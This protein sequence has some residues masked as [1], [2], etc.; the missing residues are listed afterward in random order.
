MDF[1]SLDFEFVIVAALEFILTKSIK[2]FDLGNQID[3][4][5]DFLEG[6]RVSYIRSEIIVPLENLGVNP[7]SASPILPGNPTNQKG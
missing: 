7:L 1:P 3:F 6:G 2:S 5:F 4:L